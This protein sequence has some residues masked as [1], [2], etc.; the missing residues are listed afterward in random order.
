MKS[1]YR[2][3]LLMLLSSTVLFYSCSEDE[4]IIS[5]NDD[6]V[7][8]F[9]LEVLPEIPYPPDNQYNPDRIEL[10]RLLFYDPILSAENASS[11]GTCHHPALAFGDGRKL[12]AG[13]SNSLHIG[14]KRELGVSK[15]T[16]LPIGDVPRNSPT[17]FNTAFNLDSTG[18]LTPFGVMFWD[19]RAKGLESQAVKPPTSREEM[20]G[21]INSPSNVITLLCGKMDKIPEY[22][23]LFKKAF[24]DEAKDFAAR[25]DQFM[26]SKK[27]LGQVLG[28]FQRELVTRNTAYDR[29]VMGDK[30]ALTE[31]QKKGLRLFFTKGKCATC[32][33]GPNFSDY[34]FIVQG[35]PQIGPG[36]K[37]LAGEDFGREE[38]TEQVSGRFAFRTP[39]LRNVSLTAPYMHDGVFETLEEV[40]QFYNNASQ[41]RHP[42]VTDNMLHPSLREP[43]GLTKEEVNQLVEFMH[44]LE[45]NGSLLDPKLLEVPASVPSGM[46]PLNG[47][48]Y[49]K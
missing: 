15:A 34:K 4:P 14:P 1:I 9:G 36:K 45:D 32:H 13:V 24:P 39:S 38:F 41:P 10:G 26:I 42:K 18:K 27:M 28:A 6:M 12:P 40:V 11:C 7:A 44:A 25:G 5:G 20:K 33:S 46:L 19:G 2:L 31:N 30:Q 3:L 48:V 17:V 35:V 8:E 16:N 49:T 23:N 22:T 37:L 29:F 47:A 43:L 21:D